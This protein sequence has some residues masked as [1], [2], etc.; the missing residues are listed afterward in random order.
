MR[1]LVKNP[2]EYVI[3]ALRT[4]GTTQ[5]KFKPIAESLQRMGQDLLDF[6]DPS[7][8]ADGTAWI[9]SMAVMGRSNIVM[10]LARKAGSAIGAVLDPLREV[11]RSNLRTPKEIV[12]HYLLV[13]VDDYVPTAV[14]ENLYRYMSSTNG[15]APYAFDIHDQTSRDYKLRGLIHLV[16]LLPQYHMN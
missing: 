3:G 11:A 2:A 13:M 6:L 8:H 14:R 9:S 5:I 16:M 15:G 1:R 12:D 4:T 7:G 10:E